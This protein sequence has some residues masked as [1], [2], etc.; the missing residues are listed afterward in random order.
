MREKLHLNLNCFAL[1]GD[2]PE[3]NTFYV[4]KFLHTP[5]GFKACCEM[6]GNEEANFETLYELPTAKGIAIAD[7]PVNG[8]HHH[9]EA[10]CYLPD[11]LQFAQVLSM[12]HHC[13]CCLMP[14]QR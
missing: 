1:S 6:H 7:A 3:R 11:V 14:I 13:L 12:T 5:R 2:F 4:C 9:V 8:E 10:I